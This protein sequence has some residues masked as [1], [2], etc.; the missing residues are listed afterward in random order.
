SSTFAS[1]ISPALSA[2]TA[3]PCCGLSATVVG[4]TIRSTGRSSL[5]V[6][7]TR[8]YPDSVNRTLTNHPTHGES[9]PPR[10]RLGEQREHR[11]RRLPLGEARGAPCA[12]ELAAAPQLHIPALV[13]VRGRP[14]LLERPRAA[15][16]R[17]RDQCRA[18]ER[19]HGMPRP[20]PPWV[21]RNG[22]PPRRD[23]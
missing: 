21:D 7:V 22:L 16:E 11:R 23:G 15:L 20:E 2:G 19:H 12:R 17:E 10:P 8:G 6:D 4:E 14:A 13:A 1:M 18:G 3:A 9:I 5:A